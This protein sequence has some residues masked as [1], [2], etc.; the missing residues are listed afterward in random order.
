MTSDL[1]VTAT[2]IGACLTHHAGLAPEREAAVDR[3]SRLSYSELAS[4]VTRWSKALLATGIGKGDRVAMLTPP[5]NEWLTVML[6]VTDIGAVW[7]GY[8]PRYRQP[9]FDHVTQLAE[10]KLLIAFR[11]IDGRDYSPELSALSTKFSFIEHT[12]VLDDEAPVATA[13]VTFLAAA[14]RVP[15]DLLTS[16]HGLVQLDDTAVVIFTSGTTGTPK[17]AMIKHRALLTGARVENEHWLMTHPRVLHMMPVNHI[18]GVGMVGVFGL[19]VG[20]TLVFQ[21]RFEPGELLRLLES[22]RIQHVLGSPVQFHLMANHPEL[23]SRNLESL[24]F[25]TWGGAPMAAHLVEQ[26][27]RLPG[28]LCTAYGMTE[29]G[30]YV[31]FSDTGESGEA[32][33][34]TIGRAHQGFD[35]RVADE[36]GV[37][38]PLG[39][40]GE[41]QARGDWLLAGYYRDAEATREAFTGDG[42]FRTGD[43]VK[44]RADGN[45]EIV[46]RTKE[47]YISGGFNIYPREI[48]IAIESH[49]G[50]GLVAVLGVN[51]EMFGEVGHAFVEPK[52]GCTLDA[53]EMDTWCR[54]R[55][56]NYK[57]PKH[58]SIDPELPRLPI[59]KIDKQSLRHRLSDM[60]GRK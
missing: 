50:V 10:P 56:A 16:A 53:G 31:T 47:M 14:E 38:T 54:E 15:D 44:V 11:H 7:L 20:G 8:H 55:L 60:T 24:E 25:I 17:G 13:S 42:W 22:E 3:R 6:A 39:G 52:P 58:W 28:R 45:L 30:L 34:T 27:S 46:G 2:R 4:Q 49:P 12:V 51:D 36:G 9:E 1:P 26:L 37:E 48:E 19:Y 29:L 21:D 43:V 18:A 23:P 41:I 59:G 57:V 33:S 35:I 40:Q 5:C 32:L